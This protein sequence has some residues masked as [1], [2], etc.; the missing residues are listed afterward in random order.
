MLKHQLPLKFDTLINVS[1]TAL[2]R[3]IKDRTKTSVE[4]N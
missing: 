3:K 1:T 2:A 4:P